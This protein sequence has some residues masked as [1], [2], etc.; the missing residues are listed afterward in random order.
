MPSLNSGEAPWGLTLMMNMMLSLY[1]LYG[2]AVIINIG[3]W[4]GEGWKPAKG[5]PC[6]RLLVQ[7]WSV[8]L[9]G[10]PGFQGGFSGSL[11]AGQQVKTVFQQLDYLLFFL[12]IGVSALPQLIQCAG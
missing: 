7:T 8:I 6:K 4:V 11:P 9:G 5:K 3:V 10:E 2:G 1:P 12:E